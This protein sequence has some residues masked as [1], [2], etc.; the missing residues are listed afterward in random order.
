MR[1]LTVTSSQHPTSILIIQQHPHCSKELEN[2]S[3]AENTNINVQNKHIWCIRAATKSLQRLQRKHLFVGESK[4]GGGI[5][6]WWGTVQLL[7]IQ[8]VIK[9]GRSQQNSVLHRDFVK[10]ISIHSLLRS[11]LLPSAP[12]PS[13]FYYQ[14]P[15]SSCINGEVNFKTFSKCNLES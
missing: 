3:S 7:R 9:E 15:R 4:P 12:A 13:T 2:T 11:L 6:S 10:V 5:M 14:N 8:K 1:P